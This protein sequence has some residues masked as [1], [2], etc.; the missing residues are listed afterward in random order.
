MQNSNQLKDDHGMQC[1]H[2]HGNRTEFYSQVSHALPL[3]QISMPNTVLSFQDRKWEW[4]SPAW[5]H[6]SREEALAPW[7]K[8]TRNSEIC[9]IY[10]MPLRSNVKPLE[11]DL[12]EKA[13]SVWAGVALLAM[14]GSLGTLNSNYK[15]SLCEAV[16][17]HPW[18]FV[19]LHPVRRMIW[20]TF[21]FLFS[22]TPSSC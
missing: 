8:P 6:T 12:Q 11:A 7:E 1:A 17:K 4:L 22:L 13:P 21:A 5:D 20:I 2:T 9:H 19:L 10:V 18:S 16:S 15:F 14:A 3:P